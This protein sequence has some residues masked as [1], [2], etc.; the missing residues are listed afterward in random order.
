MYHAAVHIDVLTLE[1]R[2][3][4]VGPATELWIDYMHEPAT[5]VN[6]AIMPVPVCSF[7]HSFEVCFVA[8]VIVLNDHTVVCET[9]TMYT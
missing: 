5:W 2:C 1:F 4:P 3:F 9:S 6:R 7:K 8:W